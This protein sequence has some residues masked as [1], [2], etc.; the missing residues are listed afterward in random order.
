MTVYYISCVGTHKELGW[1]NTAYGTAAMGAIF[2]TK[3]HA[4]EMAALGREDILIN[5]CTP[6]WVRTGMAGDKAHLSP[7]EGA[8]TPVFLALLPPESPSG[9][10]WKSKVVI[11]CNNYVDRML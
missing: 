8:E 5:C 6:G 3:V 1:T 4:R 2:L 9:E 7:D 11:S 10:L